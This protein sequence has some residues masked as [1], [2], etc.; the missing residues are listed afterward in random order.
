MINQMML[1]KTIMKMM[2]FGFKFIVLISLLR[3][4]RSVRWEITLFLCVNKRIKFLS[5]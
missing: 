2:I 5:Y 1:D 3:E 4:I